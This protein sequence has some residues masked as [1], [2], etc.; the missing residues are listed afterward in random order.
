MMV[1]YIILWLVI[2]INISND[3]VRNSFMI[4][5]VFFYKAILYKKEGIAIKLYLRTVYKLKFY[6]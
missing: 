6:V 5:E 3:F 2:K 4:G 1:H